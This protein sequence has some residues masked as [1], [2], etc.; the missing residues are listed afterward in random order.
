MRRYRDIETRWGAIPGTKKARRER[1]RQT[2]FGEV[3]TGRGGRRDG[4]GRPKGARPNTRH[5][6]RPTH[7]WFQPVHVTMRRAKGLPSF[8]CERLEKI[9]RGEICRTRETRIG[10]RRQTR[11]P[12]ERE[13]ERDREQARDGFRVIEY[14]IQHD[15][16]H[17]IIEADDHAELTRGMRSFVIR[18]A[19]QV[20]RGLRRKG[21]VWGDRYH[22]VD[23]E[24]PSQVRNVLVYVLSNHLKHGIRDV[25]P[26][27]PFSSAAW[28]RDWM[29]GPAPPLEPAATEPPR[30]WLLREGWQPL[31]YLNLGEL[32]KRRA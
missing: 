5:R 16:L 11:K 6:T 13:R 10:R 23:L 12:Q 22:R 31:G 26:L 29:H 27:D 7:K 21:H 3:S 30:T 20:N 19:L 28:F 2:S 14:S 17:M 25:G 1:G 9:L 24:C 32:P 8:R 15:H 4:A 18:A